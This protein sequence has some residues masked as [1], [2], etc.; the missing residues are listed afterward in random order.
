MN[1]IQPMVSEGEDLEV[2]V[3]QDE[4]LRLLYEQFDQ[5]L[6]ITY[7]KAVSNH[8]HFLTNTIFPTC[9]SFYILV[10]VWVILLFWVW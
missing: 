10:F 6:P 2:Y 8:L 7:L 5:K 3:Q 1:K 9:W 4:N